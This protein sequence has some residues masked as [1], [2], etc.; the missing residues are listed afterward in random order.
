MKNWLR[1]QMKAPSMV[2]AKKIMENSA[3]ARTFLELGLA[4]GRAR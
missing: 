1:I 2:I 3:A 4:R